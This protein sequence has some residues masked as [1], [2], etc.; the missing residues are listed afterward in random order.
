M[1]L[2]RVVLPEAAFPDEREAL[3]PMEIEAD[4]VDGVHP[5]LDAQHPVPQPALHREQHAQLLDA[6]VNVG[7]AHEVGAAADDPLT[8][9]SSGLQ[10]R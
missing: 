3:A 7:A 4:T 1:Q 2:A 8:V 9:A 5:L 10:Q 6:H